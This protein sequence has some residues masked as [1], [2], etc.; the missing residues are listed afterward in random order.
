[1]NR[2]KVARKIVSR[3]YYRTS[4]HP[5]SADDSVVV[6]LSC[7]HSRRFKGS[8]EPKTNLAFCFE[9]PFLEPPVETTNQPKPMGSAVASQANAE[10]IR[11]N[12]RRTSRREAKGT[13]H[14]N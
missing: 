11:R 13:K 12:V 6:V 4:S 14:G 9:C 10:R 1:M 5:T 7:G 2:K 3:R 8:Q